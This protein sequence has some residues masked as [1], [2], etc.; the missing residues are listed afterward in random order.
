LAH[1]G[2]D[3][4]FVSLD[5]AV[6]AFEGKDKKKSRKKTLLPKESDAPAGQSPDQQKN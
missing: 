1:I 2:E 3:H 4:I 5:S 6:K